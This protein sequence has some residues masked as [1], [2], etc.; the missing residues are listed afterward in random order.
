MS[1]ALHRTELPQEQF[2]IRYN[3]RLEF[4]LSATVAVFLHVLVAAALAVILF[5]F[6]SGSRRDTTLQLS[7]VEPMGLDDEGDG[8]P[9]SGIDD[10]QLPAGDNP[11]RAKNS[12]PV[13][14]TDLPKVEADLRKIVDDPSGTMP[15]APANVR[16]YAKV[17]ETL[18]KK[19]LGGAPGTGVGSGSGDSHQPGVGPGGERASSTRARSLRWVLR[20]STADGQDY[21]D[22]LAA[23]DA[24]ILIPLPPDNKECLFFPSLKRPRERRM[25]T[26]RDLQ[27]LAGQVRFSDSRPQSVGSVCAAL[28]VDARPSSFWAFF[29]ARVEEELAKKEIGYR[30]RRPEEIAETIFRLT[31]RNGSATIVV[32]DQKPK[33]R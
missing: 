19:L 16:G 17:D 30:N 31:V 28:G 29:P 11:L 8:S 5:H 18:R 21:V 4:P 27:K 9:G 24:V 3:K 7:L 1:A 15:I 26:E 13:A 33:V 32:V 22:Q 2:W 14:P 25:A 20:F 10:P 6:M 12:T 23:L